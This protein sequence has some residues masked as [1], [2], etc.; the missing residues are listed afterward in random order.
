MAL[1]Q[2]IRNRQG[3]FIVSLEMALIATILGIGLI[4]GMVA[5][6]HAMVAEMHDIA[7]ALGELDQSFVFPGITDAGTG[8]ETEGSSFQDA[9]DTGSGAP[10]I[11]A[12]NAGIGGDDTQIDYNDPDGDEGGVVYTDPGA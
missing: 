11:F 6:Q 2:K 12:E 3:G 10:G 4:V 9:D 1:K 7:E 5:I 8:A